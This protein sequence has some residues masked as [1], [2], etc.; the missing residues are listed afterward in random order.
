ME[1]VFDL[2]TF[3]NY[4]KEKKVYYVIGYEIHVLED[5]DW[6][7]TSQCQGK[8]EKEMEDMGY[9]VSEKWLTEPENFVRLNDTE[10]MELLYKVWGEM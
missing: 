6:N 7:W 8:T 3:I 5:H 4:Y 10:Y 2:T 1:K 9:G